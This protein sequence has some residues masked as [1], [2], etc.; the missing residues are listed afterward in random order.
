MRPRGGSPGRAPSVLV[1]IFFVATE[2]LSRLFVVE[3]TSLGQQVGVSLIFPGWE[4]PILDDSQL[5]CDQVVGDLVRD[6]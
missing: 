3:V 5:T 6:K 1:E 2:L 4:L